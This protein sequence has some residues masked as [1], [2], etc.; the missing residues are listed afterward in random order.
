MVNKFYPLT[1]EFNTVTALTLSWTIVHPIN[2]SSPL[3]KF[4]K[5]DFA[6]TKGEVLVF[7][8]AFDDMFS[9]TVVA[10]TSYIFNELVFGAKFKPMY[11]VGG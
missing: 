11:K 6:N 5:E 2:E 4:T 1:L 10:R 8:K 3:Y 9:N 7:L